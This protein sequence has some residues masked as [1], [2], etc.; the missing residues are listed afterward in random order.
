LQGV[1]SRSCDVWVLDNV[2]GESLKNQLVA[3]LSV[4]GVNFQRHENYISISCNQGK[5]VQ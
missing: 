1:S 4:Q 3:S 5:T 2:L